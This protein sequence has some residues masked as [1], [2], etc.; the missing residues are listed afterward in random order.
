[1]RKGDQL[2]DVL[3]LFEGARQVSV[4]SIPYFGVGEKPG[5]RLF[6]VHHRGCTICSRQR[7]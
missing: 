2:A 7:R 6:D 3:P 5:E 1:V 4:S